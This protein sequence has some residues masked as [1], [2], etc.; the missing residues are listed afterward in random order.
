MKFHHVLFS[1]SALILFYSESKAQQKLVWSDEFNYSGLPD[2]TKW[3]YDEGSHGWGNNELQYY[4]VN[5]KENARVENGHLI[6]EA[7]KE[8]FGKA[9]YTSARLVT[10]GKGDWKYGRVEVKAKLP[11][12]KGMWPA[13][14]MLPTQWVYGGWPNSGEID[15]MENVGYMP[16]SVFG[17]VHTKSFNHILGTQTTKGLW[18]N[19]LSSAFHIYAIDWDEQKVD[20]FVDDQKYLTFYNNKTG[21]DAWPFDQSFHLLLN[22]AVGGNW[23]GKYGVDDAIFPQ[24]MEVDYVRVYAPAPVPATK[25]SLSLGY[26]F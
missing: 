7:R 13:I 3:G 6:I 24:K 16:D 19:D 22:I 18:L 23:G 2:S 10:K 26:R 5:R 14:W 8:K 1:L 17:S 20:F 25:G 4:T 11:K 9:N 12:G 15:I 21:K